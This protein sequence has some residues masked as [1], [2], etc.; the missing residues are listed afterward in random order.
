[1]GFEFRKGEEKSR[2]SL[3]F[4]IYCAIQREVWSHW[5]C[6]KRYDR[7]NMASQMICVSNIPAP[8]KIILSLYLPKI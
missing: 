3:A 2:S 8:Q 4:C 5:I 6:W 1:M 7:Q